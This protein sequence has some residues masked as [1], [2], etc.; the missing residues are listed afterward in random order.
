MNIYSNT[1]EICEGESVIINGNATGGYGSLYTMYYSG[2]IIIFPYTVYPTQNNSEIIIVA[3]D[4]CK[5][6]ATDTVSIKINPLPNINF[7]SNIIE[8]CSPLT[9]QFNESHNYPS[10]TWDFDDIDHENLSL[11]HNPEH[12]FN[13]AGTYD[14]GVS[15][16]DSNGCKNSN[17]ILDMIT[18]FPNPESK[19]IAD[20]EVTTI[21]KPTID[22]YNYT[23]G[24]NSYYWDF[25]DNDSSY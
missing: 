13:S 7:S 20:P 23:T 10:Y 21:I 9:V 1:N 19:F 22:F 25:G 6:T 12:T 18:V 4:Q 8:G 15:V 17:T 5:T 11:A 14:I 24:E 16:V 3:E 2:N